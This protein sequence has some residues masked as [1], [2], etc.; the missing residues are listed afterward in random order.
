MH[1]EEKEKKKLWSKLQIIVNNKLCKFKAIQARKQGN[2]FHQ[3]SSWNIWVYYVLN[4]NTCTWV[5][6]KTGLKK[7]KYAEYAILNTPSHP[8]AKNST[9][10]QCTKYT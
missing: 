10:F 5:F 3:G 4:Y 8:Y 6:G 7:R 9:V 1:T 2:F